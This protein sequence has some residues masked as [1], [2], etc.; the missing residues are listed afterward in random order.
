MIS[1]VIYGGDV[2]Y[3]VNFRVVKYGVNISSLFIIIIRY[4]SKSREI[5]PSPKELVSKVK[6]SLV[7]LIRYA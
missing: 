3:E 6:N 7:T 4:S 2:L 1:Y 5:Y